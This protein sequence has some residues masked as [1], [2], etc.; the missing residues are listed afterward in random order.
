MLDPSASLAG[1]FVEPRG[2]IRSAVASVT[3]RELLGAVGT[4]LG[5][6]LATTGTEGASPL[7]KGELAYLSVHPDALVVFKA[8]RGAFRPKPTAD[9]MAT[10]PRGTVTSASLD[11]GRIGGVLTVLF[12]DG[13]TWAFDVPKVH[14]KGARQIAAIL[15]EGS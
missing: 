14:H 2:M 1:T 15:S 8:K 4:A 7:R 5:S 11:K 3:G 6:R 10:A 12:A 9:V 13:E